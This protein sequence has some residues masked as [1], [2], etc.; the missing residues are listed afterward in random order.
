MVTDDPAF[1]VLGWLSLAVGAGLLAL[2]ALLAW[3]ERRAHRKAEEDFEAAMRE[4][5]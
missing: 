5:L 3:L 2:S 4:G 1:A